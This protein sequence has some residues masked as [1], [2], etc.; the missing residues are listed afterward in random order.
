MEDTKTGRELILGALQEKAV[1]KQHVYRVT[2]E[3]FQLFKSELRKIQQDIKK[4]VAQIDKRI[5]VSYTDK[6]SFETEIRFSGDILIFNMHSNVFTFDNN[7]FIQKNQYVEEDASR[8][9]CGMIQVYNFLSDSFKF[10]RA[11]DVGYMIARIFINK[12]K[13]FFVEGKRQLGF[14]YN[15]FDSSLISADY[16]KAIIESII[17]Y[18]I[19]FDLLVPPYDKVKELTVQQ[20]IEQSGNAALKTG[21]RLGFRFEAD[22]DIIT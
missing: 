12:E 9:Y 1:T 8:A 4:E 13:H 21:K 6:G 16:I 14:L 11:K 2:S 15:E 17:L 20:K 7:H 10:N 19:D 3:A 18:A 22:S 5:E